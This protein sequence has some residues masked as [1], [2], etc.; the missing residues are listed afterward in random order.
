MESWCTERLPV[1]SS[2]PG[3]RGVFIDATRASFTQMPGEQEWGMKQD[4]AAVLNNSIAWDPR[5]QLVTD[6]PSESRGVVKGV[7]FR[8]G[9][10]Q[11]Q[12][13][14]HRPLALTA[15]AGHPP[16]TAEP[17]A[18]RHR[19]VVPLQGRS[20][21]GRICHPTAATTAP[22]QRQAQ[23]RPHGQAGAGEGSSWRRSGLACSQATGRVERVVGGERGHGGRDEAAR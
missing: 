16:A 11:C 8:Q 15:I 23:Q 20:G 17:R 22:Q 7:S 4:E 3:I 21:A 2:V 12:L 18:Q 9:V 10:Q 1:G 13:I 6:G 5:T 19:V 14:V